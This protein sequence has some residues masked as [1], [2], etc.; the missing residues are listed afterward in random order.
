ML[1]TLDDRVPTGDAVALRGE[2][3]RLPRARLRSALESAGWSHATK[4]ISA[5]RFASVAKEI[6][7]ATK[8]PNAVLDGEICRLDSAGRSSFSELQQGSGPLVFYAFDLLELDH[9]PLVD[10]PLG[11]RK[12]RLQKLLDG[13]NRTVRF[14]T[15]FDDGEALLVAA[16]EQELEG[17]IAKRETS[18]YASGKRT[19]DWLKIKLQ[20]EDEFVVAGY[21]R[22]T[23]HREETFGALVLAVNE[24]SE[25]RYVGN[26]GTGFADAEIDKLL[27]LLKPLE[28]DS[29]PFTTT[30]KMARVRKADVQWVEPR[31]VVQVGYGEWTHDGRL[32]HPVYLG[33]RDDRPAATVTSPRSDARR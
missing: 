32:R 23:G 11:E 19:R 21:T 26:V 1:A 8:S 33:L 9:E 10:L 16:R 25:L 2:V 5:E 27:G 12:Q 24:G 13:R 20:N 30:P 3:R 7:K 29:A 18:R 4:T 28:R 14:S 6:V 31:L 17:I 22:G 15:D